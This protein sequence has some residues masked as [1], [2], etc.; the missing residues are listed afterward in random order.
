M[1]LRDTEVDGIRDLYDR[2]LYLQAYEAARGRGPLGSWKGTDSRILAGRLAGNLG[3]R[4]L[5]CALHL[6]AW[7]ADRGHPEAL[8]Y[9]AYALLERRGPLA[10]WEALRR[11]G[12]FKDA[13]PRARGDL[14]AL[15]A[16]VA[17]TLRDFDTAD[18]WLARAEETAPDRVWIDVERSRI[19]E[20]EDRYEEALEA[21]RR[22]LEG[23]P[24]YRPAVQS[25]AHL[26]QLL[27]RD[28]EALELLGEAGR[29]LESGSVM[30]QLAALQIELGLHAQARESVER[31]AQLCPLLEKEGARWLAARRSDLAYYLGDRAEA[32]R[33]APQAGTSFYQRL[34]EGLKASDRPARRVLLPVGFVRQHHVTC[35]PATLSAISRYW[36]MPAEHLAVAERICY[37]GTPSHSERRWAEENGWVAR[38]FTVTWASA[39]ALLDRGVPFTLTTVEPGNAHLQALIGYDDLRRTLLVRDPYE[40]NWGEFLDPEMFERHRSSGPRG[41]MLVPREKAAQ[42]EG[43]PLPEAELYDAL[44]RLLGALER[45]DRDEAARSQDE[46]S[47]R[48][49]GHRLALWGRRSLAAYDADRVTQLAC[50]EEL[51][52]LYPDDANLRLSKL[53]H[54]REMG[55]REER[56]ELLQVE[57]EREGAHPIFFQQYARELAADARRHDLAA[58]YCLQSIRQ[59]PRDAES[60]HIL[61]GI[62][63]NRQDRERAV[64]LYRFAASLEDKNEAYAESYFIASRHL[65][66]TAQAILFLRNRFRRFGARSAWPARTLFWAYE[67]LDRMAEAFEVLEEAIRLRPQDGELLLYAAAAYARTGNSDRGAVLLKSAE[68]RSHRGSW[69]RT[70]AHLAAGRGEIRS[71]LEL[72]RSIGEVEPLAMDAHAQTARLLAETQGRAAAFDHL[73]GLA[74]RFPHHAGIHQLWIEW[75]RDGEAREHEAAARRLIAINPDD[76]WA[77]RELALVLT[78]ERRLD[79]AV[80]LAEAACRLDP[81]E[82]STYT[83]R[84]AVATAAGDTAGAIEACRKSIRLSVDWEPALRDLVHAARTVAE[85]REAL[86]FIRAELIRQVIFGDGLLT[87]RDLAKDT[88]EPEELLS[89][90]REAVEARPDLWHAWAAIVRQTAEMNRLDEAVELARKATDRFPLVPRLW[91]DL[92]FVCRLRGDLPGLR[93]ALEQALRINPSW[94]LASR[95]LAAFLERSGDFA[96]ARSVLEQAV[97]RLPLDPYVNERLAEIL[98]KLGERDSAIA[99]MERLVGLEPG[100]EDAW[101]TLASWAGELRRPERPRALAREMA[102]RRSGDPR[103]WLI[104]ARILDRPEDLAER[105]GALEKASELD[106]RGTDARDLRSTLLAEAG[107]Y[108]EALAACGGVDAPLPLRGRSAWVEAQRGRR[109]LAIDRMRSLLAEDPSY[110]WGWLQVADWCREEGMNPVYLEAARAIHRLAPQRALSFGYLGDAKLRTGDRPGAKADL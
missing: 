18:Q 80:A 6:A 39:T 106:P 28:Q 19:L 32:A 67:Q 74:D 84:A 59:N 79:E 16:E 43:V 23:R 88:L 101:S 70:A 10:A 41:M 81:T 49:P 21:A 78:R 82:P 31:F 60:F 4:R 66:Q 56:L 52:R 26:L 3:A 1:D 69:L 12:D 24:W 92:A 37:D 53:G 107:R 13:P 34:A 50:T 11:A 105:L 65:R 20:L 40:R 68:G 17:A 5:A 97:A 108:D 46:L 27:D 9:H 61:A 95:E 102:A 44:Y 85:R 98:W 2:G 64:D 76:A 7:R 30:G 62:S 45:H 22:S 90:L 83:V 72:W 14:F 93:A 100:Y 86:A 87:Y 96:G 48:A 42:V 89:H 29:R 33:H 57:C 77:R 36:S 73:R 103:S 99:R 110:A 38:E 71:A 54:L 25:A 91:V 58:R 8:Y 104:L 94:G 47:A 15:V 51:L 109:R 35:A 75:L 55:R 63:W